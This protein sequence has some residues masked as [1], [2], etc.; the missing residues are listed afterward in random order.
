MDTVKRIKNNV[1]LALA[2]VVGLAQVLITQIN[3]A[4][5]DNVNDVY[6]LIVVAVG[7]IQRANAWGPETVKDIKTQWR[8]RS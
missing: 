2:L 1:V 6:G 8:N 7:F 4:G 5:I 3:D